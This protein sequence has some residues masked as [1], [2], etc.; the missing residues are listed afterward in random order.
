MGAC[1]EFMATNYS[2]ASVNTRY[3][4]ILTVGERIA[5]KN[6]VQHS[7]LWSVK[8]NE[9]ET[10]KEKDK[11]SVDRNT[12]SEYVRSSNCSTDSNQYN[13]DKN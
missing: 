2:T 6:T 8:P 3:V 7:K 5:G 4:N 12:S 11:I 10:Q 1:P 9:A 13:A